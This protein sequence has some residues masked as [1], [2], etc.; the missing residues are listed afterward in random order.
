M[1]VNGGRSETG[2]RVRAPYFMTERTQYQV[3]ILSINAAMASCRLIRLALAG[4][5]FWRRL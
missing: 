3:M 1:T 5:N 2:E 4:M